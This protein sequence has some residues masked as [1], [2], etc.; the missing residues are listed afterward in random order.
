MQRLVSARNTW[1]KSHYSWSNLELAAEYL[2][3]KISPYLLL[4]ASRMWGIEGGL[5]VMPCKHPC[6]HICPLRTPRP[7][8]E[9]QTSQNNHQRINSSAPQ[10]AKGETSCPA[11]GETSLL[12]QGIAVNVSGQGGTVRRSRSGLAERQI[13]ISNWHPELSIP[14]P[15]LK[16]PICI[17]ALL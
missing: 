3:G 12:S 17:R 10:A 13:P 8:A 15:H 1:P 16:G 6:L 5:V 7:P 9:G 2:W 4:V 14:Q 11:S